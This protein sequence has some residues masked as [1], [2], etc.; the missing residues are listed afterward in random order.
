MV[1]FEKLD[2]LAFLLAFAV[3][4]FMC[5]ITF[6]KPKIIIRHPTPNNVNDIIYNDDRNSCYKYEAKIVKCPKDKS[7]I[8]KHPL[9]IK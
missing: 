9:S 1:F 6:P 5:Y 7:K 2:P 4:I 3:G 8:K